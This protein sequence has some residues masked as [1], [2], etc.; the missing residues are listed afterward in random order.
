MGP[1]E[2][3]IYRAITARINFL[4]MDRADHRYA[5]KEC[6]R[7][8]SAPQNQHWVDI[9]GAKGATST[10]IAQPPFKY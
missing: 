9:S 1:K 4:A 2:Q 3:S 6:P 5:S 8:V 7:Y 10:G